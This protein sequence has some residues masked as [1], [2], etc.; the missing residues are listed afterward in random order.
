MSYQF[1]NPGW[2]WAGRV[3][4]MVFLWLGLGVVVGALSMPPRGGIFGLLAGAMAGMIVLPAVGALLGLL[5]GRWPESL[6][7]A[8][9]GAAS[10]SV[11]AL[12]SG[13]TSLAPSVNLSLLLG[14]CVGAT[15]PQFYRLQLGFARQVRAQLRSSGTE[16]AGALAMSAVAHDDAIN[17]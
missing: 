15:F 17:P 13:G 11:I 8:A 3:T 6:V 14:A 10:G 16:R 7:G 12:W 2:G 5:G 9:S 1:L 4:S